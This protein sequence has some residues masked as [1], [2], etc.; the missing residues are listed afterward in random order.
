MNRYAAEQHEGRNND[1][2]AADSSRSGRPI[3]PTNTKSPVKIAI[4]TFV[5]KVTL[6]NNTVGEFPRPRDEVGL[7][8][9]FGGAG[10]PQPF[11]R[12]GWTIGHT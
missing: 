5:G 11:R 7:N 3:E 8:V 10:D 2:P 6:R 4:G 9:R 12:S 1:E